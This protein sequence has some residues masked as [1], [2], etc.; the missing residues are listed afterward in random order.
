[1]AQRQTRIACS[2]SRQLGAAGNGRAGAPGRLLGGPHRARRRA[3]R[4]LALRRP[5]RA[6]K[7]LAEGL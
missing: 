1:V 5:R 3:A 2:D 4:P 6:A 7:R